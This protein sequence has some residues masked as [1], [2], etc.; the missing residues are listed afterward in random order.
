MNKLHADKHFLYVLNDNGNRER[1]GQTFVMDWGI[2]TQGKLI[3]DVVG[4]ANAQHIVK[5][6]NAYPLLIDVLKKFLKYENTESLV[7]EVY[8]CY[9]D[10]EKGQSDELRDILDEMK[11]VINGLNDV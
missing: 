6:C 10:I 1:I 3:D 4:L 7:D 5:C 8:M 9:G 11:L 2:D